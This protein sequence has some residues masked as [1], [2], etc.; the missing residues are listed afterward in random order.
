MLSLVTFRCLSRKKK[1]ERRGEVVWKWKK[2]ETYGSPV[3]RGRTKGEGGVLMGR[4]PA[5]DPYG[6]ID[7]GQ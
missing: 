1:R 3:Q 6:K 5:S 4:K 7:I 2:E